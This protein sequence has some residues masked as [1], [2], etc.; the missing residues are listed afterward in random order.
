VF[1]RLLPELREPV[2][3]RELL[4][5]PVLRRVRRQ[6]LRALLPVRGR[7]LRGRR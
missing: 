1:R 7:R 4:R 5:E 3:R 6:E 2:L